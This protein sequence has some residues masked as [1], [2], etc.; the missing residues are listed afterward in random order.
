M[1]VTSTP[2]FAQTLKAWG[3]NITPANTTANV[4]IVTGGTDGSQVTSLVVAT[5]DTAVSNIVFSLFDGTNYYQLG[6]INIPANSGNASLT[7][8]PVDVFRNMF[9]PGIQVDAVGN[10][11]L[12]VPAGW[13]L[14]GRMIATITAT[15]TLSVVAQ[16]GDY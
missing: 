2:I 8:A 13:S 1:A 7:S 11:S 15:K 14:V 12:I 3:A 6:Y 16:G 4:T 9:F 10:K 5:T